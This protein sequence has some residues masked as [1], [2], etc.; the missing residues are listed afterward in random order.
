MKKLNLVVLEIGGGGLMAGLA[1]ATTNPVPKLPTK[2]P[3]T[4]PLRKMAMELGLRP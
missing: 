1:L 4:T 2:G 3:H